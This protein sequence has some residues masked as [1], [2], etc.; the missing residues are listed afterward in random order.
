M[1]CAVIVSYNCDKVFRC[2]NSIVNQ[3]DNILIIDN[4]T[5]DSK[6]ISELKNLENANKQLKVIYN[7]D[8]FGIA[9]ALNQGLD[10]ALSIKAEW[11]LTLDHDSEIPENTVS[12]LFTD[13]D[14]LTETEKNQCAVIALKYIERNIDTHGLP[15]QGSAFPRNDGQATIHLSFKKIKYAMTSGNF[16]KVSAAQKTGG[17]EEKMFIDQ[18]DN[19]FDFRLRK[20]GFT[21]L[22]SKNHYILHEIGLSQ[23]RSGFTIRN[24]SP[25]RRYYLS[26]NCVY[27]LKKHFFFDT[28]NVS[29]I[30]IGSIFGGIFKIT[31]FESDKINKYKHI[32]LGIKDGIFN[33]YGKKE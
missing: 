9:K 5:Q 23:K 11:L 16:V 31:F 3:V 24:Y 7:P 20:N 15:R 8:N 2:Y 33:K 25:L 32:F 19:D 12:K 13:Y 28:L 14:K 18:V 27:I 17:F 29:R 1:I 6:I 21:I 26:R 30:F 4:A 22:E 10:Y